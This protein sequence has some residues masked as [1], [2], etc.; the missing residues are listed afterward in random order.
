M[1]II[2]T[3]PIMFGLTWLGLGVRA[4]PILSANSS[5]S[6][7]C[8]GSGT[9]QENVP[10]YCP[11]KPGNNNAS[12]QNGRP[13]W[14]LPEDGG[15]D[16]ELT[17]K[18]GECMDGLCRLPFIPLGCTGFKP[19]KISDSTVDDGLQI[20]CIYT[21]FI[22]TSPHIEFNYLEENVPCL[23]ALKKW[24]IRKKRCKQNEGK[25]RCNG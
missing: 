23:H 1:A 15:Y 25:M 16:G 22:G 4:G 21:C 17:L 3:L 10:S 24:Y 7:P 2:K 20:G 5:T 8:P 12:V 9:N 14:V 6:Y 18:K 11:C 19:P 13:C